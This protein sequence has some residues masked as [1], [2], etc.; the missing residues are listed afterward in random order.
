MK[1][2]QRDLAFLRQCLLYDDTAERHKLEQHLTKLQ[3]DD[4]CVRRAV[5]FMALLAALAMMGLCYAAVFLT[6]SPESMTRFMTR[7]IIKSLCALGLASMIC[8][9]AFIGLG[10]SY[11]KELD[12]RREECRGLATKLLESRL[13][14]PQVLPL[15]GTVR[16]PDI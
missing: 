11:R 8:L 13:G 5:W 3:R 2:H 9:L 14:K 16:E 1:D 7:F 10:A 12:R 4:Q 6:D 15:Q